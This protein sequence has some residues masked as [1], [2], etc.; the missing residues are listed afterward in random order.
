MTGPAHGQLSGGG[1]NWTYTPA[2]SYNGPDSFTYRVTDRGDPDNCGTPG[3]DCAA[4]E[5]SRTATV[6]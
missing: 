2:A 1:Q 4:P 5:T 6:T 3:P